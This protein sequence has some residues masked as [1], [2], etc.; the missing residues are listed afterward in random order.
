[1]AS[2]A[3]APAAYRRAPVIVYVA[4]S[5]RSGSTL[6]ERAL[7]AIPGFVNVGEL[8][9][10]SRRVADND[11]LC[12]CGVT[13][14]TCPFWT[15]VGRRAFGGWMDEV[16][17]ELATLQSRVARQ[18]HLPRLL[19]PAAG[20]QSWRTDIARYRR[21]Y[22]DIYRAIVDD[23][24]GSAQYVV[25]AS[26]W[27]AQALALSGQEIDLRVIHLV[28]DA[29]GV[30]HSMHK[31]DVTR[32]HSVHPELMASSGAVAAAAR[33]TLTQTEIDLLRLT[34][35]PMTRMRYEDFV[36]NPRSA[37]DTALREL[38]L[39]PQPG[40][41]DHVDGHTLKLAASHGL[42]GNPS[43]FDA[44][45]VDLRLDEA[46]RTQL[47]RRTRA[48]VT[49][50]AAPQL[51]ASKRHAGSRDSR[52]AALST[53]ASTDES[54]AKPRPGWPLVSVVLP[55]RGR[56]ELVRASIRAVVAQTYPGDIECLVIHD[57]ES[58]DAELVELGS[59]H[60]QVQVL[61]NKHAPGLAGARN[62]GLD[63]AAG[64]FVATCDDDDVWHPTKLVKQ[65]DRLLD[66]PEL[67]VVGSGI[68]L[69]FHEGRIVDWPGRSSRIDP[70]TLLRNRVKELHSSTLVMRR[71]A[72]AKAGRYDEALPHGYAE[73]Y[74]WILRAA[75]V[76]QIGVVV[77]PLAD[78][79]KDVQSWFRERAENTAEALDYLL[80]AHPE[81]R[82][83]RRGHARI[84]GQIAFAEASLGHRRAALKTVAQALTRYPAAPHAYL[85]L[86]QVVT[87]MDPRLT[88]QAARVFR[89]GLS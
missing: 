28:R 25:D 13:F 49:A 4:G 66:E 67:L 21:L 72:F 85:A 14:S 19:V 50:I 78:I 1:M 18:R 41:L 48:L 35:L 73:D 63:V 59:Q 34:G 39:A 65:I 57:H 40:W 75:R 81:L 87:G 84:L 2:A 12:G 46:W 47:P 53:T 89:R 20:G 26:K 88:L 3:S 54:A 51:R 27:P 55:T 68:R 52:Q 77:E 82:S 80:K 71:D 37:M 31:R 15:G 10:L 43:R 32:P 23:D 22:V 58:P 56:P 29:R 74:D 17:T 38:G 11:E 42:S 76:G 33:W 30:T 61:S 6:L 70:S 24:E 86:S 44:G 36:S 62:T 16:V 83:S 9:D 69:L 8:I 60:R 79:R 45:V 7:G 5:G 64:E